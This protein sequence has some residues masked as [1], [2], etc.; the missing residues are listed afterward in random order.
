MLWG[1]AVATG[2]VSAEIGGTGSS[3]VSL[4]LPPQAPATKAKTKIKGIS[5]FIRFRPEKLR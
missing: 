5:R 4:F 3:P 2:E 1:G